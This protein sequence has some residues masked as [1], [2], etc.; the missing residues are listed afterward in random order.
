MDEVIQVF[1]NQIFLL[2]PCK[3]SPK[4]IEI[5]FAD[6]KLAGR[7]NSLSGCIYLHIFADNAVD[8]HH[9]IHIAG[10]LALFLQ[11]VE[12][13]HD[14]F[15]FL[16]GCR[17]NILAVSIFHQAH[18]FGSISLKLLSFLQGAAHCIGSLL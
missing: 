3:L 7:D 1:E 15:I 13:G 4:Q 12:D 17:R 16:P 8:C 5:N 18:Q 10:A 14:G 6:V 2:C 11:L 9:Q